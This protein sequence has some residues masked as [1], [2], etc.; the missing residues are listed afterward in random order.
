M[1]W[2]M[3]RMIDRLVNELAENDM[4]TIRK[5][6][7]PEL[8]KMTESLLKDNYRELHDETIIELYELQFDT[9]LNV[10]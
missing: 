10:R 5:M 2:C 7:K 4:V 3:S 8:V 6:R 9:Y 1:G